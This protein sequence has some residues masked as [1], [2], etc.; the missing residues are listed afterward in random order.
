[1]DKGTPWVGVAVAVIALMWLDG[2]S[3]RAQAT[4][5]DAI[6][7][8]YALSLTEAINNRDPDLVL[9]HFVAGGTVTFDNSGFAVPNETIPA[10]EYAARHR[11][12]NPDIP[13]DVRLEIVD[14]SLQISSTSARWTWRQT[15]SFLRSLDID[16][17]EFTV[18]AETRDR[19]FKSL[20]VA[21]TAETLTKLPYSPSPA[22]PVGAIGMPRTG[23]LGDQVV[24]MVLALLSISLALTGLHMRARGLS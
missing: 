21:P 1:M 24:L 9:E 14:G 4:G 11:P 12:N 16:Y 15:A 10:A 18:V 8:I 19:R 5:P 23:G 7:P 2:T 6:D 22:A 3:A 17:I 13:A 20:T